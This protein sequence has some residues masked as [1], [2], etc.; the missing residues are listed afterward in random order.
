MIHDSIGSFGDKSHPF[1]TKLDNQCH[2]VGEVFDEFDNRR[3]DHIQDWVREKHKER[4][5]KK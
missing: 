5:R 4:L 2:F 1:P 3:Q